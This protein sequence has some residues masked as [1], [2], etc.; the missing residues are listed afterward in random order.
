MPGF[1]LWAIADP[2]QIVPGD[3]VKLPLFVDRFHFGAALGIE[4]PAGGAEHF[5]AVPWG[6]IVAGGD[7]QAAVGVQPLNGQADRG[8]RRHAEVEHFAAGIH[9]AGQH[10]MPQHLSARPAIPAQHDSTR[11]GGSLRNASLEIGPQGGGEGQGV[12]GS[13][14]LADDAANS[15]NADDQ[16]AGCWHECSS[17]VQG[18]SRTS[19]KQSLIWSMTAAERLP[20]FL[21]SVSS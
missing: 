5:Q 9:E 3:P 17:T 7:L 16:I 19:F 1:G 8:R 13:Q 20:I 2:T 12:A 10:R 4:N 15:R 14:T 21:W 11:L 18:N 6:R